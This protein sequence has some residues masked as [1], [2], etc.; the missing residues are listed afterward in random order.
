MLETPYGA[1]AAIDQNDPDAT[2]TAQARAEAGE[3]YIV[4]VE[5]AMPPSAPAPDPWHD[6]SYF[7]LECVKLWWN[8]TA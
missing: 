5:V 7:E 2:L 4:R 3:D 1:F 6:E 8:E